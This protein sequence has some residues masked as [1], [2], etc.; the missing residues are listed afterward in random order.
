MMKT[1]HRPRTPLHCEGCSIFVGP[2]YLCDQAWPAPDGQGI[3]CW[4]CAERLAAIGR[5]GRDTLQLL[6]AWRRDV[7]SAVGTTP[8]LYSRVGGDRHSPN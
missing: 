8:Y 3:L 7:Q 5:K 1:Q 4:A 6:N 2:G